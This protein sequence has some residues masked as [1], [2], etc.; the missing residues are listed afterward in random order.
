LVST[1]FLDNVVVDHN[2]KTIFIND[3]KTTG[4]S[5]QDFPES[6]EY[7][8]YWMQAVI[9]VMLASEKFLKD[10]QDRHTGMFK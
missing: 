4:K 10:K 7:Y 3:L 6:V 2:S 1:E 8:K 9:Y 5:I